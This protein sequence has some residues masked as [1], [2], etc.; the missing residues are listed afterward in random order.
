MNMIKPLKIP[1][2]YLLNYKPHV[3]ER[4]LFRRFYC[5]NSLRREKLNDVWVQSNVSVN[6]LQGTI[7]GM[8]MLEE[9]LNEYKLITC[10]K[11]SI[12]DVVVDL[13][14]SSS[15]YG[16]WIGLTL[17]ENTGHSI[18]ISPGCAHGFQTLQNN[19]VLFYAHSVPYEASAE[20]GLNFADPTLNILWP[21]KP[22]HI[23]TRD[24]LLPTFKQLS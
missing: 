15:E 21:I 9:K 20:L 4:G 3:D 24:S 10:A 22:T 1:G 18:Y 8:H 13:R 12:F 16:K 5:G 7:R 19:T 2:C 6:K 14:E 17:H 11:G 23:S